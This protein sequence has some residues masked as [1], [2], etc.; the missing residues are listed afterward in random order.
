MLLVDHDG[1]E[2]LHRREHRG[3]GSHR[4]TALSPPQRPPGVG[5]LAVRQPR[6]EDR[7]LVP[8]HAAHPGHG[9]GGERDLGDE[10]DRAVTRRDDAT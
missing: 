5:A 6:V 1:G 3:T 4:H 8:E 7:D 9:L 10:E 2:P